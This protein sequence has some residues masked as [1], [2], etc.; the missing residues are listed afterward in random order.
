[1]LSRDTGGKT[2][3]GFAETVKQRARSN[4]FAV[5]LIGAGIAWRLY[6]KPPVTTLLVGAGVAS[7]LTSGGSGRSFERDPYR[8]PRQ[9]G[10]VPGGVAGYDYPVE[11]AAP[12]PSIAERVSTASSNVA[13]R[14][15]DMGERARDVA[16]TAVTQVSETARSAGE[17]ARDAASGAAAQISD[18]VSGTAVHVSGALPGASRTTT[19]AHMAHPRAKH[20]T[21]PGSAEA[22][23]DTAY[24]AQDIV[25]RAAALLSQAQQSPTA[26]G[27]AGFVVGLA[28]TG[29]MRATHSGERA[30]EGAKEAVNKAAQRVAAGVSSMTSGPTGRI[31]SAASTRDEYGLRSSVAA[32]GGTRSRKPSAPEGCG[33]PHARNADPQGACLAK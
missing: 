19:R 11:E 14:A 31:G 4:P 30:L 22:G 32:D 16:S 1:M 20:G 15:R 2:A 17:W 18:A 33:R 21:T 9:Q 10:Y 29:M 27:T 28:L 13:D 12:T 25:D 24:T 7:L 26:L 8:N 3:Q 5:A 23:S 6:K